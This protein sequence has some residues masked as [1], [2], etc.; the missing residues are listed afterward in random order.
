MLWFLNFTSLNRYFTRHFTYHSIE[1]DE[2]HVSLLK[3]KVCVLCLFDVISSVV[4][5]FCKLLLSHPGNY[6]LLHFVFWY[7]N[8]SWFVES[9][10]SSRVTFVLR[11]LVVEADYME[12]N[13]TQKAASLHLAP[14]VS[15]DFKMNRN[16]PTVL[17][18]PV[19]PLEN[20]IVSI[21]GRFGACFAN[22]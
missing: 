8:H 13:G 18:S 2:S 20:T 7:N 5:F 10:N 1:L 12:N 16:N 19:A 9:C 14:W 11:K 15:L 22:S 17:S 4:A 21:Q 6:L 3:W